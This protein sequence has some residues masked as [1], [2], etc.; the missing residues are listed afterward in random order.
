[1]GPV[2]EADIVNTILEK[3]GEYGNDKA[4]SFRI[5]KLG[6]KKPVGAWLNDVSS[7]FDHEKYPNMHSRQIILGLSMLDRDIE[8][9]LL[10]SNFLSPLSDELE[11]QLKKSVDSI[12]TSDGLELWNSMNPR[13]APKATDAVPICS[14]HP[15]EVDQLGKKAFAKSIAIR[16]RHIYYENKSSNRAGAFLIHIHGP[17][18]SGKTTFIDFIG[19]YLR[20]DNS[21]SK[22]INKNKGAFPTYIIHRLWSS[23][24]T[25]CTNF[26]EKYLKKIPK[27]DSI[28]SDINNKNPD[29]V[30]VKFNA[31]QH[32]KIG[33]PWWSL[34]DKVYHTA[35]SQWT[36]RALYLRAKE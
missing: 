19:S 25:I 21:K 3:H 20:P 29:W 18:G 7:L 16:L 10:D 35:S 27:S 13:T 30:V 2:S 15:S 12:L 17:W 6:S 11:D 5:K 31:W 32:Q 4:K 24:K 34:M 28:E 8:G 26:I 9:Q 23:G 1:M 36:I 14:D 33:P 22:A